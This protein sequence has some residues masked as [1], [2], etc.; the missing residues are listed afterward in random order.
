MMPLLDAAAAPVTAFLSIA[1]L[2]ARGLAG[3]GTYHRVIDGVRWCWSEAGP[4]DGEPLILLHGFAGDKDNWAFFTLL[5]AQRYR[6]ICPDLPGFGDSG[7]VANGGYSIAEQA[8][9]LEAFLDALGIDAC[10]LGGNSMGGFV[11][12]TFAL[13]HPHR[14]RSLLLLNNAGVNGDRMTDTQQAILD[15]SN[16]MQVKS[17]DDVDFLLGIILHDPP[18]IP[19]IF[20]QLL[21]LQ[22]ARREKLHDEIFAQIARDAIENPLNDR[23]GDVRVPTLILWGSSDNLL[24]VA[25]ATTQHEAIP[26]AELAIIEKAGHVPMV[27]R[28]FRTAAVSMDFLARHGCRSTAPAGKKQRQTGKGRP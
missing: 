2:A 21:L 13:D 23:L 5:L 26:G 7:R 18:Y 24:H 28:P 6:V 9:R 17:I 10:H 22:L 11:A 14:L 20:R 27:E 12:L 16:P 25:A 8:R 4:R 3:I 15:G 19:L 1:R